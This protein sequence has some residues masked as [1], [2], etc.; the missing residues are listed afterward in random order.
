ATD[1][2]I[3]PSSPATVYVAFWNRGVYLSTNGLAANPSFAQMTGIAAG[4]SRIA[5][6]VAPSAPSTVY[7]AVA[8]SADAFSALYQTVAGAGGP[9]WQAVTLGGAAIS[10]YGAYT[11]NVAVDISTPDLV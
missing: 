9:T 8:D 3:D 4:S 5:L 2:V 7:A 10:A 1:V 6:A 11:L